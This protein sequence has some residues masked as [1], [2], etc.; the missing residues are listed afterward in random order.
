[1]RDLCRQKVITQVDF[2]QDSQN[3]KRSQNLV[4]ITMG[5]LTISGINLC[6]PC[7]KK[8]AFTNSTLS[9]CYAD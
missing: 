8:G 9:F 7:P 1:M 5:S 2:G 4:E 6:L 3:M